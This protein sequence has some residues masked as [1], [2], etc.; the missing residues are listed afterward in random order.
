MRGLFRNV[1][2]KALFTARTKLPLRSYVETRQHF[3]EW[4]DY[5]E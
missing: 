4:D 5:V 3:D 2:R 1:A